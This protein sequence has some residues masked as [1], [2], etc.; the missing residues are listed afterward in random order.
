MYAPRVFL[1]TTRRA[2]TEQRFH[3]CPRNVRLPTPRTRAPFR[4]TTFRSVGS[5]E[6]FFEQLVHRT[7][8]RI[9]DRRIL[10]TFLA[11]S[12]L[13]HPSSRA[14]PGLRARLHVDSWLPIAPE[15]SAPE[16]LR[17]AQSAPLRAPRPFLHQ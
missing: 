6:R 16:S 5:F 13:H 10:R 15:A 11:P 17:V 8:G 9:G 4:L 2:A 1:V 7:L 14:S 3:P 12:R